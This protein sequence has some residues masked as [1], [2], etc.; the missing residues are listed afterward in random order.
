VRFISV[1]FNCITSC[2]A[3]LK[4]MTVQCSYS[5]FL[6]SKLLALGEWSRWMW[7]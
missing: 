6:P 3:Y 5:D 2:A 4:L 7:C 1:A